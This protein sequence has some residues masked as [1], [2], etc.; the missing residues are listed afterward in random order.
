MASIGSE[1]DPIQVEEKAHEERPDDTQATITDG[2]SQDKLTQQEEGLSEDRTFDDRI[3]GDVSMS[4]TINA[5]TFANDPSKVPM[6]VEEED[7]RGEKQSDARPAATSAI[8][9]GKADEQDKHESKD[10][11]SDG[12]DNAD[13]FMSDTITPTNTTEAAINMDPSLARL[14]SI[15]TTATSYDTSMIPEPL[16]APPMSNPTSLSTTAPSTTTKDWWSRTVPSPPPA[17]TAAHT[18]VLPRPPPSDAYPQGRESIDSAPND[19]TTIP[20]ATSASGN[21]P[22]VPH[23]QQQQQQQQQP[24][25]D[26]QEDQQPPFSSIQSIL[27]VFI[28][29]FKGDDTTFCSFPTDLSNRLQEKITKNHNCTAASPTTGATSP[30]HPPPKIQPLI[31]PPFATRGDLSA[32]VDRFRAWLLEKVIDKE[33]SLGTPSPTVN[34]GVGVIIVGHSMGGIMGAEAVLGIAEDAGLVSASSA[35]ASGTTTTTTA[36]DSEKADDAA[37][38]DATMTTEEQ[39]STDNQ[40]EQQRE[41]ED[42]DAHPTRTMFPHILGLLAFDTP[43]LGIAPGVVR[44][45]A[46]QHWREGKSWYDSTVGIINAVSQGKKEGKAAREGVSAASNSSRA[47]AANAAS[48]AGGSSGGAWSNWTKYGLLAAGTAVVGAGAA[49]ASKEQISSGYSWMSG[50]LEFVGC[51]ARGEELRTRWSKLYRLSDAA[52]FSSTSNKSRKSQDRRD[53]ATSR[54]SQKRHPTGKTT[55]SGQQKIGLSVYYT[56]LTHPSAQPSASITQQNEER[57]FVNLP[58]ELRRQQSRAVSDPDA[59]RVWV[60]AGNG[61]ARNE[62]DAHVGMFATGTNDGYERLCGA[63][64]ERVGAWV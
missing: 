41:E 19:D 10:G 23:E 49:Y 42:D 34:P 12:R 38:S 5:A 22:H 11:V 3:D 58:A 35:N 7:S 50:H 20:D 64:V 43:F 1:G 30:I 57:T 27:L 46:E 8:G 47:A 60:R 61:T 31:Y 4:D 33:V 14:T 63:V 18:Q 6:Q 56:S 36:S 9:E 17:S 59:E 28:H 45:G 55:A 48:G 44:H 53:S 26:Q 29:G 52:S 16:L 40:H 15:S 54:T 62:V 39:S 21:D 24:Q 13:V 51:L 25:E 37:E 2:G 32:A